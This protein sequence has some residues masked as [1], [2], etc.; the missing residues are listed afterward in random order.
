MLALGGTRRASG[1]QGTCSW[2]SRAVLWRNAWCLRTVLFAHAAASGSRPVRMKRGHRFLAR[3]GWDA[4][5]QTVMDS[6]M[7]CD[8]SHATV[9]RYVWAAL[10]PHFVQHMI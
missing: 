4:P 10:E 3:R 2:V 5:L 1:S 7:E 8:W 9:E 6:V